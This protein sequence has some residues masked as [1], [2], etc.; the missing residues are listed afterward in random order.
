MTFWWISFILG[1]MVDVGLKFFLREISV[2]GHDPE[3]KVTDLEFS[4]KS[5]TFCIKVY[6]AICIPLTY[7]V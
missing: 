4:Y 7:E 6:L 2:P 5:Q 3:V 1:M